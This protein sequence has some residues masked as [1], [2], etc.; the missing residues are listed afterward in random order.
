MPKLDYAA[1]SFAICGAIIAFTIFCTI[2]WLAVGW[3]I[4]G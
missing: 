4:V 1:I 3:W 2:I